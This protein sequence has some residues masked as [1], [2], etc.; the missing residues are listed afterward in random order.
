MKH[1]INIQLCKNHLTNDD[2]YYAQVF[3]GG[4]RSKEGIIEMI[5]RDRSEIRKETI[6]A[7][8]AL[9]DKKVIERL[10]RGET[11]NYGFF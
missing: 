7:A 4:L 3:K 8:S 1:T 9:Y 2:T 6:S 10:L 11:V 5:I